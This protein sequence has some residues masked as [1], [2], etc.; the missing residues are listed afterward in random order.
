MKGQEKDRHMIT[1]FRIQGKAKGVFRLIRLL[2][3]VKGEMTLGELYGS[4]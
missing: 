2:A 3:T 4:K 1:G